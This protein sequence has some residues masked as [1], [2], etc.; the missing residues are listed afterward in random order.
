MKARSDIKTIMCS[1]LFLDI[2]EY[3]RQSVAG[4]ISLKERFNRCLSAALRDVSITDRIILDAGDGA[5]INFIGDVDDALKVAVNL[6]EN[7]LGEGANLEPTL[8]VRAGVNLGPVRLVRDING[9]PDIVGDGINVA[10]RIMGFAQANQILVSRPYYDAVLRLF[11]QYAGVFHYQ[12]SRTDKHVREHE[13]YAVGEPG[14]ETSSVIVQ[15]P[16]HAADA[17]AHV[18]PV[19]DAA[20]SKP[21]RRILFAGAMAI[22]VVLVGLLTLKLNHRD[23]RPALPNIEPV[24]ALSI[25][26]DALAVS[27]VV[28][29]PDQAEDK[30]AEASSVQPAATT[31]NSDR[32]RPVKSKPDKNKGIEQIKHPDAQPQPRSKA[33]ETSGQHTPI[34]AAGSSAAKSTEALIMLGCKEGTRVFVD[35]MQ[36]GKLGTEVLTLAL[37]P[38]KHLV[39][40]NHPSGNIYSQN[41]DL[42]PGKTLHIRPNFCK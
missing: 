6:R 25:S 2:V 15:T 19:E 24:Q 32:K 1:V 38:G 8:Q 9:H 13:V 17:L 16:D 29:A 21:S 35:G 7:M 23:N 27:A 28:S 10:H 40:V 4:Q 3:S 39:I 12:G 31:L 41:V 11:P 36:K 30:M 42:E 26:Q 33:P 5:A 14:E 20:A 37:S 18:D 34:V 22:A